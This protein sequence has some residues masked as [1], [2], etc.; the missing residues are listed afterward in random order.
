MDIYGWWEG[1]CWLGKTL[2]I[3]SLG[4]KTW[5]PRDEL[6]FSWSIYIYRTNFIYRK[7]T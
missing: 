4:G 5:I 2:R 1:S 7:E 6:V 3:I